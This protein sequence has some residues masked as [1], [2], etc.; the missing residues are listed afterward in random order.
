MDPTETKKRDSSVDGRADAK[1]K[2]KKRQ[3]EETH[4]NGSAKEVPEESV[5]NGTNWELLPN[6][7][8][9]DGKDDSLG[10][11]CKGPYKGIDLSF[12]GLTT[13]S[14]K[15]RKIRRENLDLDYAILFSRS[16]A[17]ALFDVLEEEVEYFTG[18]L[19]KGTYGDEGLSYRYSGIL[20]PARPWPRP[21]RAIRDLLVRVTGHTFNFV[22]V[23]RY[24]DGND[25][26]GE[27]K[28]DEKELD[29]SA[30][31]ASITLGQPRDFYFKHQDARG[32]NKK[33]IDKVNI[34]LEHGSLLM[35]NYP[36]N[37]YWY[38]A[39]PTRKAVHGP[40][41]NLTFRTL[42]QK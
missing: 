41:I 3:P 16:V 31:I 20:T 2:R 22:L 30:P 28:D 17:D 7:A 12:D 29:R 4:T 18:D 25:H 26:M 36:T 32:R 27:H 35:M 34:V 39:L 1:G 21:L 9:V 13:S 40:R 42:I 14:M 19:A 33:F 10:E 11:V 23:N 24:Q 38:H 8:S 6:G 37:N 5:A 15:W